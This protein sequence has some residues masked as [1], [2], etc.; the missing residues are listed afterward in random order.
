MSTKRTLQVHRPRPEREM[1]K[2]RKIPMGSTPPI[3]DATAHGLRLAIAHGRGRRTLLHMSH[4]VAE[5]GNGIER[6]P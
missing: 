4:G 2:R 1:E 5:S 6:V 3:A